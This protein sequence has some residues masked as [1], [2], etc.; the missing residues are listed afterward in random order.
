MQ[1]CIFQLEV[2]EQENYIWIIQVCQ[3]NEK[4]TIN[5]I[6]YDYLNSRVKNILKTER[7]KEGENEDLCTKM[8]SYWNY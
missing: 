4:L 8:G 6:E 5:H 1:P 2:S 3:S 7:L